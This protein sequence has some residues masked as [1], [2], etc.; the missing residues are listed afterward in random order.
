MDHQNTGDG[1]TEA[2]TALAEASEYYSSLTFRTPSQDFE[3]IS[4]MMG[5]PPTMGLRFPPLHPSSPLA[6][7]FLSS[8]QPKMSLTWKKPQG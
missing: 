3:H 5:H 8:L 6:A 2:A 7:V 4:R 1:V